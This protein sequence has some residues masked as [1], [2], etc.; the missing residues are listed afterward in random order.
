MPEEGEGEASALTLEAAMRHYGDPALV[1]ELAWLNTQGCP[2]PFI[3]VVNFSS[4][5]FESDPKN[6]RAMELQSVLEKALVSRLQ[7]GDLF[8]TGYDNR[9][10][11]D[12]QAS[13]LPPDRWRVLEVDF[14]KSEATGQGF[15]ISGI[16]VFR[17]EPTK[18]GAPG[19]PSSMYLIE[20]EFKRRSE[21]GQLLGSLSAESKYLSSWLAKAHPQEKPTTEK[22][23]ANRLRVRYRGARKVTS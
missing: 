3:G 18:T 9:A 23:I 21:A 11:I 8:A 12:T 13:R 6:D 7:S 22:T 2:N 20:Q 17:Q 1:S 14:A 4:G 5:R 16:L 19:R 10:P 15:T